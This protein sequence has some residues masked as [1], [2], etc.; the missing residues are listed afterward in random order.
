V[1]AY[2]GL[3]AVSDG[4]GSTQIE[5]LAGYF[6]EQPLKFELPFKNGS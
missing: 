3:Q 1:L 2:V 6:F 4:L 5:N